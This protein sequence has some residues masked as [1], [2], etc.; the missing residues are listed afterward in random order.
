M[1]RFRQSEVSLV[2]GPVKRRWLK[3][4]ASRLSAHLLN[5]SIV[6]P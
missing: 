4:Y 1:D 2:V 5:R 3:L 6:L